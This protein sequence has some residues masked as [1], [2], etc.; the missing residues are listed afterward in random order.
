MMLNKEQI[1]ALEFQIKEYKVTRQEDLE[2][3]KN[4][5]IHKK[6]V[7]SSL[8]T[9]LK[10]LPLEEKKQMGWLVNELKKQAETKYDNLK[11]K[12]TSTATYT[13][14]PTQ[15]DITLPPIP[16]QLGTLH[17]ITHIKQKVI[18]IL[19][20]I[21]FEQVEGCEMVGDKVNFEPV[22]YTHLTLPTTSR[23]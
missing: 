6:G 21:G 11:K 7:I 18:A 12:L 9:Q 2:T 3:F 5:F 8:F 14:Y 10:K 22:S 1:K 23:V 4:K 17:P 20:Q 16:K 19:K 15:E 13:D